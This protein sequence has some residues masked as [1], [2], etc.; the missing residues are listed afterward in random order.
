MTKTTLGTL[1]LSRHVGNT[2]RPVYLPMLPE[3][4]PELS[5]VPGQN[6]RVSSQ[7]SF[8]YYCEDK[9]ANTAIY[10]ALNSHINKIQVKFLLIY[11]NI[12]SNVTYIYNL[13]FIDY[14]LFNI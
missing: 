9:A 14:I 3:K 11:K 2:R 12:F 5:R 1:S 7:S 10:S 4:G 6:A 8:S 13:I